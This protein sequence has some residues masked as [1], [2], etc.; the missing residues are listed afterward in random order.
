M[1][2]RTVYLLLCV[3]GVLLP[4]WQIAPWLSEHG[5]DLPLFFAQLFENR[6]GAFFGM[7]VFVSAA[8]LMVFA[9]AERRRAGVRGVWL[10]AAAV[11]A[12]GISLGLP[13]LLYLRERRSGHDG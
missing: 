1:R 12:V 11:A 10:T 8:A 3:L 2:L 6:V 4:Y 7:D 13:L 9:F 5:L